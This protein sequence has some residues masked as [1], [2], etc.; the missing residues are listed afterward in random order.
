MTKIEK[1]Q[2]Q[3]QLAALGQIERPSPEEEKQAAEV[4]AKLFLAGRT[5]LGPALAVVRKM[6]WM[7][8][9][10]AVEMAWPELKPLVRKALVAELDNESS[11]P[12]KRLSLS[13]ARG[14]LK[15]DAAAALQIAAGACARMLE[16]GLTPGDRQIFGSVFIGRGKPWLLQLP[17]AEAPAE[18]TAPI[19]RCAARCGFDKRTPPIAQ[20]SMVLWLNA[21]GCLAALPE[22]ALG[23][24]ASSAVRWKPS[25]KAE[26]KKALAEIP[27]TLAAAL[28]Q[29]R[30]QPAV[31]APRREPREDRLAEEGRDRPSEEEEENAAVHR[32]GGGAGGSA[33][34]VPRAGGR[35]RT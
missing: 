23:A 9:V 5:S 15:T 25:L 1:Q 11:E 26:A 6:P 33:G 2:L 17:L 19:A 24:I 28:E 4:T 27:A 3:D 35:A 18:E 29:E 21:G 14:L 13:I 31:A 10:K 30:P 16:S 34:S 12:A 8:G 22:D 32:R 20:L 7:V